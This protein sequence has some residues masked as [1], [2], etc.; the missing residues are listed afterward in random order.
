MKK[1]E[2][3]VIFSKNVEKFPKMT[4]FVLK[5]TA[6]KSERLIKKILS[7]L[8][9]LTLTTIYHG[10]LNQSWCLSCFQ[11]SGSEQHY[12]PPFSCL[13]LMPTYLKSMSHYVA[14]SNFLFH[15]IHAL[16]FIR[17]ISAPRRSPCF[18][19]FQ[20]IM[21]QNVS[22]VFLNQICVQHLL[23]QESFKTHPP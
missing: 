5:S 7:T 11:Y 12:M 14:K 3:F 15:R 17:N 9:A 19:R 13:M 6:S 16:F 23:Q 4:N 1:Q 2:N 8:S 21:G 18:L 20:R 22:Y 10:F